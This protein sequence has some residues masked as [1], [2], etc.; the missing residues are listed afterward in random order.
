MT[1]RSGFFSLLALLVTGA[2]MTTRLT[3]PDPA[4]AGETSMATK[5]FV[6]RWADRDNSTIKMTV[7]EDGGLYRITGG[8]EAYGYN[9]A[10]LLKDQQAVCTG[11]GGRLEGENFL[12]Q[13]TFTFTAD[14]LAAETWKAFNNLQTVTGTTIWKKQK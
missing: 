14:G 1:F 12:Y 13:S 6:G 7:R 4:L 10:C 3:F 9:I 2:A 8:D 5:P 11:N